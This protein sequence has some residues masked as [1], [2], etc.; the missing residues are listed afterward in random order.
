M[1]H[2]SYP[3]GKKKKEGGALEGQICSRL[4]TR[5]RVERKGF[6]GK[7]AVLKNC[8]RCLKN[9]IYPRSPDLGGLLTK[10]REQNWVKRK[11]G[12]TKDFA[13]PQKIRGKKGKSVKG[14]TEG[15]TVFLN[16]LGPTPHFS[17]SAEPTTGK[18]GGGGGDGEGV[19]A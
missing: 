5:D 3:S 15:H 12:G 13:Q 6:S 18:R 19:L 8:L 2:T 7:R 9:R 1:M 14:G 10:T 4:L 17:S 11:K 16:N